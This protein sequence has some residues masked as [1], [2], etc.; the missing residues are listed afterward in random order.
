MRS[1]FLEN[2]TVR[3]ARAT[4]RLDHRRGRRQVSE[5][6]SQGRLQARSGPGGG[7]ILVY[8]IDTRKQQDTQGGGRGAPGHHHPAGGFPQK[9][10]DPNDLKNIV[11]R[12][13]GGEGRVEIILPT[14]GRYQELKARSGLGDA[15]PG[16]AEQIWS[17]DQP[18]ASRAKSRS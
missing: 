5:R 8:E 6:R 3:G 13:A 4:G 10:I 15:A 12:P 18:E 7:T 1:F 9:R 11:I 17:Q 14:G 2:A 16:N